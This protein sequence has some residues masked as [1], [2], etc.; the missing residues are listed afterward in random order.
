VVALNVRQNWEYLQTDA[1]ANNPDSVAKIL[2]NGVPDVHI[3]EVIESEFVTKGQKALVLCG[4]QHA[5]TRYVSAQYAKNAK[6]SNLGDTRR[7]GNIVYDRISSRA[8]AISL[9]AP[10]PDVTQKIGFGYPVGGAIDVMIDALPPAHRSGGWNTAG[11]PLGALSIKGSVY[12]DGAQTGTLADL[13][14]GYIV[15]GPIVGYTFVT[16]IKDFVNDSNLDTALKHYPG[17]KASAPKT[18]EAINK[19]IA[20]ELDSF[21][22]AFAQFR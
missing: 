17:V 15:M 14:D 7:A 8:F 4:T 6:A 13:F 16:P 12:E 2:A 5:F 21:A 19:S 3:A 18:A 1:D 9:H 20:A 11:T 22:G 10:W